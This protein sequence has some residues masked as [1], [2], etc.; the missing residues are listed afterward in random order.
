MGGFEIKAGATTANDFARAETSEPDNRKRNLPY[1]VGEE[2]IDRGGHGRCHARVGQPGCFLGDEQRDAL[3]HDFQD[4][5][6]VARENYKLALERLRVNELIAKEEDLSWVLSL[7]LDLAGAHVLA[8]ITGA[9]KRAAGPALARFKMS[10]QRRVLHRALA[11]ITPERIESTT[12]AV[13]D[14][15][16]TAGK[17]ALGHSLDDVPSTEER[18]ATVAYIDQLTSA[19]DLAFRRFSLDA[20]ARSDDAL[21]IVLWQGMDPIHHS[22]PLY[23]QA[24][25]AKIKRFKKAGV[26]DIGE[27]STSYG[28]G[29]IRK[30]TRVV[31]VRDIHG[32]TKAW[33][34]KQFSDIHDRGHISTSEWELDR[35]VPSEFREIAIQRS[36]QA[37]GPTPTIDDGFVQQLKANGQSVEKMRRKLAAQAPDFNQLHQPSTQVDAFMAAFGH[38][39]ESS[40][41]LPAGSVFN[42]NKQATLSAPGLPS[43]SVFNDAGSQHSQSE[44]VDPLAP[45]RSVTP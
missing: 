8:A 4:C 45:F 22:V 16:K 5:V 9:I 28:E 41:H 40:T 35:P 14:P 37:W 30:S 18:A 23:E 36:E 11:Q 43:N 17:K 26:P 20:R 10:G 39:T 6:A 32:R 13:F 42:K 33:F 25:G 19:C 12:K 1:E 31:L 27:K 21:L 29:R 15:A 34:E 3:I 7:A 44:P 24:L 2:F 38:Y